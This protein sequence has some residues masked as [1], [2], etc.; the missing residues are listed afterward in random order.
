MAGLD[1]L[2]EQ[3]SRIAFRGWRITSHKVCG[4]CVLKSH[5]FLIVSSRRVGIS[6]AQK[7]TS[8]LSLFRQRYWINLEAVVSRV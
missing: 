5:C 6:A 1:E 7:P 2:I 3:R 8:P 4:T